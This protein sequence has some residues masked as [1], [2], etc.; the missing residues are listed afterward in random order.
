M[1][2]QG[3]AGKAHGKRRESP[4]GIIEL[5]S[6]CCRAGSRRRDAA[7]TRL[8]TDHSL[9]TR[10]IR[11][12][13]NF[14]RVAILGLLVCLWSCEWDPFGSDSREIAQGYRLKRIGDP[15]QFAFLAPYDTGGIIIDQIGWRKPFIIARA[16]GSQYWDRIDTDHA[17]HIRISDSQ[18]T[19]NP[20]YRTIPVEN[21]DVAWNHLKPH[22]RMW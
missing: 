8:T 9:R 15:S 19:S 4:S 10:K 7:V 20:D 16:S 1:D 22:K 5:D 11:Q 13:W 2:V 12:A 18:R 3:S 6:P 17:E 21:A 14:Y